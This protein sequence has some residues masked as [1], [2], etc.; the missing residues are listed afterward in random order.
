VTIETVEAA[1]KSLNRPNLA[2]C[3]LIDRLPATIRITIARANPGAPVVA[4]P[5]VKAQAL[6]DVFKVA[7]ERLNPA[8]G[9]VVGTSLPPAAIPYVILHDVYVLGHPHAQV[10]ARV[11]LPDGAYWAKRREAVQALK[12]DLAAQEHEYALKFPA[13]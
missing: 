2:S 7:I 1:L 13:G 4:L 10:Q 8:R 12:T 11:R 9:T 6:R 3:E 5:L